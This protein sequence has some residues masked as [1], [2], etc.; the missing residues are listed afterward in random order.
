MRTV[1]HCASSKSSPSTGECTVTLADGVGQTKLLTLA[2]TDYYQ[3]AL[4]PQT[5]VIP[6][7]TCTSK[8]CSSAATALEVAAPKVRAP[9]CRVLAAIS[10]ATLRSLPGDTPVDPPRR[11]R[12]DR[13]RV[14]P[15]RR[16]R[17]AEDLLDC[18]QRRRRVLDV[19][20]GGNRTDRTVSSWSQA[21]AESGEVLRSSAGGAAGR[22]DR[23]KRR[24]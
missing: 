14:R 21:A 5:L 16:R 23:R 13:W 19:R 4:G 20:L 6:A 7:G 1:V 2:Y 10:A 24:G 18:R 11:C 17:A 22:N 15:Q 3:P 9:H 12:F 8:R